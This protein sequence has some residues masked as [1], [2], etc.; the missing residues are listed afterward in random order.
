MI[1]GA[2]LAGAIFVARFSPVSVILGFS[3][4]VA[5]IMIEAGYTLLKPG[6]AM[7]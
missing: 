5:A 1:L 6:D 4:I 2:A 7:D 3:I